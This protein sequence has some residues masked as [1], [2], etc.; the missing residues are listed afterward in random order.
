MIGGGPEHVWQLIQHLP[1]NMESF[2]AAP[3]CAPYGA[4]FRQSVGQERLLH[5]PQRKFTVKAF[6]QL[7]HFIKK[8]NIDIIHSHG[9]GAG[10]YGRLAA[11]IAGVKSVHTFHGIHLP[12]KRFFRWLYV[13]LE[14]FLCLIS[15]VCIAVSDGEYAKAQ[16]LK[17][18]PQGLTTIVNGVNVPQTLPPCPTFLPLALLHV[19]RFD[20]KQKNSLLL[21]DIALALREKGILAQCHFILVG[22]G[23]ELPTLQ[24]KIHAAGLD[25]NFCIVGQQSCVAP[26]Y[27]QACCLLSTSRWEGLPLAVLEATAQGVPTIATDVVGNRDAIK[28]G[29][30]GFLYPLGNAEAAAACIEKILHNEELWHKMRTQA[31]AH[32]LEKFSVQ[33]MAAATAQIYD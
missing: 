26:Y 31:Y 23:E 10:I 25:N 15:R 13:G 8:N 30:T 29:E 33:K 14:R 3:D 24:K 7:I 27:T 17:L 19:S 11:S 4:R 6:L 5:I 18:C 1:Q 12:Q 22:D 21:Y 28:D 16:S 20:N 2:V 32:A 9:K